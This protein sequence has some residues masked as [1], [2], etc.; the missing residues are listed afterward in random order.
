[1]G[2][3]FAYWFGVGVDR[4]IDELRSNQRKTKG[5][6][7]WKRYVHSLNVAD[8]A[9]KLAKMYGADEEKAY[10]AGVV[11][12][13]AK[14][15]KTDKVNYYVEKYNIELDELEV[16][17]ISLS[18]SIIGSYVA[19]YDFGIDDE[20]II[21]SVRYH[22]TGKVDMNLMEKI[23]YVADLIE[24]GRDY[25]GVEELRELAYGGDID[26]AMIQSFDNTIALMLKKEIQ[27]ILDL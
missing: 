20:D 5:I 17:N 6:V 25:P 24:V 10:L 11:H 2:G 7:N 23:I 8:S 21:S 9:K 12:D 14:Y 13:C 19:K 18:H 16:G 15:F 1:M 4:R 26:A 3:K 27:F 22:T